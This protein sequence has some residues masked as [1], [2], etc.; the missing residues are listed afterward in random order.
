M[1][2]QQ[3]VFA[4]GF[5]LLMVFLVLAAQYESW[6]VPFAVILAVPFGIF[7]ALSAVWVMGHEQ[8][9]LLSDRTCHADRTLGQE[10]HSDRRI[11]E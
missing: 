2:G 1:V 5:G 10:C 11:R 3:S 8:R 9:H 7:G 4:F 6:S